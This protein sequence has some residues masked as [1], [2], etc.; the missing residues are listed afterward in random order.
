[1]NNESKDY[2]VVILTH[3]PSDELAISL[4]KLLEQTIKPK[5]IIIY[6]TDLIHFFKR[7]SD[8][9]KLEKILYDDKSFIQLVHISKNE[10]DHGKTRNDATKLIDTDYVLFL[11]DDAV[12]YDKFL[13][14]NLLKAFDKYRDDKDVA[15][16]Y[17]RQIA[18]SNAKLKEKYVRLFN[19]PDYDIVKDKVSEK[20]LGI[21]N[22][23]CSNVCAMYDMSIFNSTGKFE[24]NVILNE[25]TFY[26]Y[27]VINEGYKIV[28]V[29][30][31]LVYHSHNYTYKEQF[32]RNF[33]IGVS[34]AERE[35]MFNSIPSYSEGKKLVTFVISKLLKELHIIMAFDFII[36][37]A[38]RYFGFRKGINYKS[39][40]KDQCIKYALNK[41]YFKKN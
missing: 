6:N 9:F 32:S 11:T 7:I 20:K 41:K 18:K 33:D 24:E 35:E 17:A 39:L 5:K 31:A 26:A 22:Y 15:V 38:F 13:C 3:M 30:D 4:E 21:K 37:C 29:S 36:E 34:Q 10:F 27:K 40:T 2:S 23:F 8:R 12:P 16:V 25:D 19:Y 14:E 28:Y 1:M